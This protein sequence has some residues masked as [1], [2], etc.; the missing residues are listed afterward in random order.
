MTTAGAIPAS[1][2]ASRR[3]FRRRCAAL[4]LPLS[5]W[6]LDDHRGPAGEELATDVA[7][8]GPGDAARLLVLVS[9][10]HGIEGFCGAAVQNALLAGDPAAM[11]PP[12]SAILLI[13]A[14]N[15]YGFAHLRRTNE[16]NV[17]LN[18]NFLDF[19]RPTP[20]NPAYDEVHPL[21]VPDDWDGPA[22]AAADRALAGFVAERG[23]RALQAAVSGGQWDHADGLF[24]GGAAP[25]WSNRAWFEILGR[26]AAA[27][28][29][30]AVIDF[31][32]GLGA[33]GACELISGA[34]ANSDELVLATR[35]FEGDIVFP[36]LSSTAPAAQGFMGA[37]LAGALP[38]ARGALVVAEFGTVPFEPILAALRADNWLHARG[39]PAS[40]LGAAIKAGMRAAFYGTDAAWREAILDR[41]FALI[42]HALAAMAATPC[43]TR[44]EHR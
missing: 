32:T 43:Q 35:W 19:S 28:R 5:Q 21:I 7:R 8:I 11:L 12:D 1:Y 30:V 13:H 22:R 31:H 20:P 15:P 33:R 42:R 44:G 18:R 26:H 27:A 3:A 38:D 2:A 34:A 4:G 24:Y 29:L 37:T 10:T 41:G 39:D 36:G 14:L 23:A 6:T 40:P 25:S 16:D 9:A 17:D